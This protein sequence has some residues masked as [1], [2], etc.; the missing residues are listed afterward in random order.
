MHLQLFAPSQESLAEAR[1]PFDRLRVNGVELYANG[2]ELLGL[3]DETA[4]SMIFPDRHLH[5]QLRLVIPSRL[6]P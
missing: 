2:V 4:E 5:L 1:S 3:I 6:V